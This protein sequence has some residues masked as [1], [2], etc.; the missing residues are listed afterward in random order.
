[1]LYTFDR[2]PMDLHLLKT[3]QTEQNKH[4]YEDVIINVKKN[5]IAK[6][7]HNIQKFI[8]N[9][10]CFFFCQKLWILIKVGTYFSR[11]QK[12]VACISNLF[13]PDKNHNK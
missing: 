13:I 4:I 5:V 2:L 9:K 8:R 6:K 7:K 12:Y 1:M 11:F 3:P 10:I